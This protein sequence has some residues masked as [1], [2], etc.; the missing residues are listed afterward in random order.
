MPTT[1]E[2]I[3]SSLWDKIKDNTFNIVRDPASIPSGRLDLTDLLILARCIEFLHVNLIIHGSIL[4][5]K[6]TRVNSEVVVHLPDTLNVMRSPHQNI[7]SYCSN[8]YPCPPES[9]VSCMYDSYYNR[10]SDVWMLGI[11]MILELLGKDYG[12]I[13]WNKRNSIGFYT[14]LWKY[15]SKTVQY[16]GYPVIIIDMIDPVP[17]NRPTM[18]EVCMSLLGNKYISPEKYTIWKTIHRRWDQI[19]YSLIGIYAR[20]IKYENG[21]VAKSVAHRLIDGDLNYNGFAVDDEIKN[22]FVMLNG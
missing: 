13:Q 3:R 15:L 2:V 19:G 16:Y 20:L 17:E 8:K 6:L 4:T 21:V 1:I 7:Q 18:T 12:I 10:A 11:R 22:C 5:T 9:M 14:N